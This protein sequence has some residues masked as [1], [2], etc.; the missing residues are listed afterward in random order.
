MIL[1]VRMVVNCQGSEMSRKMPAM[2]PLIF[3]PD[4][5]KC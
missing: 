3:V 4:S 5:E 1:F 2:T